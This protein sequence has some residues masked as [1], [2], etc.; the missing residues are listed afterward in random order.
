M[1]GKILFEQLDQNSIE[2]KLA[3]KTEIQTTNAEVAKKT[4]TEKST[5]NGNIK[6]NDSEV[7]V[8]TH[9]VSDGNLHVPAT[10]STSNKKV[11][12]AGATAGSISWGNVDWIEL[13]SKPFSKFGV[14][15]GFFAGSEG[16]VIIDHDFNSLNY[17][18]SITPISLTSDQQ[19]TVGDYWAEKKD[20]SFVVKNTGIGSGIQFDWMI[21]GL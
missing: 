20:N 18:V 4:K 2:N 8:Y 3:T 5:I 21:F 15:T 17:F 14:G 10:G 16:S 11:L 1:A 13:S 19:G 7:P 9:P 6:I 12:K